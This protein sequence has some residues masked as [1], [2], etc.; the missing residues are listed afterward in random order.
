MQKSKK[1]PQFKG[2]VPNEITTRDPIIQRLAQEGK[3]QIF[4]TDIAAA[5][6]MTST[7]ACYPWDLVIKKWQGFLFI[8]KRD[9][10]NML[11][12]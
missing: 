9:E 12:W 5:A 11:D 3:A 6:L 7:K 1:I 10:E 8:D 4:A 2:L